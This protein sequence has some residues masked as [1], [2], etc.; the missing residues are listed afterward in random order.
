MVKSFWDVVVGRAVEP[1]LVQDRIFE[2]PAEDDEV[3]PDEDGPPSWSELTPIAGV[4]IIIAYSDAQGRPSER[5]LTCQRLDAHSKDLYLWAFCHTR[6]AV[7]Q[8]RV[9][10]ISDVS[11]PSTGETHRSPEEFFA[12]FSLNATHA[13]HPGWGLSVGR[14]ADLVALLNALIFLAR[15]DKKYHPLERASLED[16]VLSYWLRSEA[17]GEP[18]IDSILVY[19][20][21]L[22]PDAEVFWVSLRRCAASP[23]LKRLLQS[24]AQK[25]VDAD[26][27]ISPEENYWGGK[28]DSFL[29]SFDAG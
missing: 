1:R 17:T 4:P 28:L 7:R 2:I 8:F 5:L 10:R 24:S 27:I 29:E 14:K 22:S 15:C 3:G 26:G 12:Q 21:K 20:D 19:A 9:S 16:V 6:R 13:S 25:L 23:L 11:D 18:D